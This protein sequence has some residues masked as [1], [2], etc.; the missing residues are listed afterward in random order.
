MWENSVLPDFDG[1]VWMQYSF[2]LPAAAAGKP[3]ELHLG[4][5][6]DDDMTYF[7]GRVEPSSCL[8]RSGRIGK[9]RQ[10]CCV[11]ACA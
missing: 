9:G 8:Y 6:D 1:L 3:L 5:I 2:D 4:F 11:G 10:E 7:N